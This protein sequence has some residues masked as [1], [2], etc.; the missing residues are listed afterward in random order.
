MEYYSI[1][2]ETHLFM[3][4]SHFTDLTGNSGLKHTVKYNA[5][6]GSEKFDFLVYENK[7]PKVYCWRWFVQDV[8]GAAI[9]T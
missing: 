3:L 6:I 4:S 8:F 5:R 2:M 9:N 7:C 1:F